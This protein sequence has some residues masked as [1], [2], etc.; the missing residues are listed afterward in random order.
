MSCSR[1][2][3]LDLAAFRAE[4]GLPEF[5]DFARHY[6]T[7]P[8]CA[9]ELAA[10]S[11]L[12]GALRR[13]GDATAHPSEEHLLAYQEGAATLDAN[14][15][16]TIDRHLSGCARCRSE[17]AVLRRFDWSA[18]AAPVTV[19]RPPLG[20]RVRTG[21]ARLADSIFGVPQPALALIVL[22]GL[23]LPSA[24]IAWQLATRDAG[25]ARGAAPIAQAPERPA[26]VPGPVVPEP[27]EAGDAP[28]PTRVVRSPGSDPTPSAEPSQAE[29]S[30]VAV[31]P[32][33]EPDA[34]SPATPAPEATEPRP[35]RVAALLPQDL[36]R[37]VPD[38]D[39]VGSLD[40]VQVG[41]VVRSG[42]VSLPRIRALGPEPAGVTREASPT[43]YWS[44][45]ASTDVPVELTL[46]EPDAAE[47]LLEHR[48]TSPRS[49]IHAL[50]LAD[51]RIV[52]ETGK[53]YQWFASLVPD[54]QR[55]DQDVISG[56]G[57][58]RAP[59]D[60]ALAKRL[61]E[62]P[63]QLRAHLLAAEGYWVDAFA[64]V[65]GWLAAEPDSERLR[66]YRDALIAQTDPAV[67]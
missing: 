37:Y 30:Q 38:T 7:C 58:V 23:A 62:T 12:E 29:P 55:R 43:L 65:E 60:P 3:E 15:R 34:S 20:E 19:A 45:D 17:L 41:S 33:P 40:P 9:R 57:L 47:P 11:R 54:D 10:W 51:R 67:E 39:L 4:P 42:Q 48:V 8:E 24:W 64:T 35:I 61:Q 50:S 36:P 14:A 5:S 63:T 53:A 46:V 28:T 27:M 21:L 2:H 1:A 49:G 13:A 59:A 22:L 52:L 16:Q 32:T 56:A 25:E 18:L 44:L 6:P 26:P 31:E 66:A